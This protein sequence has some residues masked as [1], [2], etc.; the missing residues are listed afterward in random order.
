VYSSPSSLCCALTAAVT[1]MVAS[2]SVSPWNDA[3]NHL[4]PALSVTVIANTSPSATG[5]LL[6]K[7]GRAGCSEGEREQGCGQGWVA[8]RPNVRGGWHVSVWWVVRRAVDGLTLWGVGW[9]Q[10]VAQ[11]RDIEF[12]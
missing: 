4:P 2:P 1:G 12:V 11:S 6:S 10:I 8:D 5:T 9:S 3:R 7:P